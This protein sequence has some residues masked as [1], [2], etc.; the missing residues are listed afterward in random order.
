V[1][2]VHARAEGVGGVSSTSGGARKLIDRLSNHP[3]GLFDHSAGFFEQL[4]TSAEQSGTSAEQ[5]GNLVEQFYTLCF[6]RCDTSTCRAIGG[7]VYDVVGG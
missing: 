2:I 4:G 3:A 1:Y 5:F 6:T 7:L